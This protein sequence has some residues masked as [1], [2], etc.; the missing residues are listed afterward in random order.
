MIIFYLSPPVIFFNLFY[1]NIYC[2][3]YYL[4]SICLDYLIFFVLFFLKVLFSSSSR[5]VKK[6]LPLSGRYSFVFQ[7][8]NLFYSPQIFDFFIDILLNNIRHSPAYRPHLFD[9]NNPYLEY[10]IVCE[11][12]I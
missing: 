3:P 12:K 2:S 6:I 4:Y 7:N 10:R 9:L 1:I 8:I 5:A 11:I